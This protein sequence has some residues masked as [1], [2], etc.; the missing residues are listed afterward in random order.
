MRTG[1]VLVG[2]G[3]PGCGLNA[4]LVEM[5]DGDLGLSQRPAEHG[6]TLHGG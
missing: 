5:G 1:V 3:T 6:N 2:G 4:A